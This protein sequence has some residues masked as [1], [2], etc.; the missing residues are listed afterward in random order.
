VAASGQYIGVEPS[1]RYRLRTGN[2]DAFTHAL[3]RR[4]GPGEEGKAQATRLLDL[5]IDSLRAEPNTTGS[6][7][8]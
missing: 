7:A 8:P 3:R 5:A 1:L 4:V 2:P 6:P